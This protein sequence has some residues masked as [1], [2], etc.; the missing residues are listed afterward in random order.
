MYL[1][2]V[3]SNSENIDFCLTT[4]VLGSQIKLEFL[5][6]DEIQ[7][8]RR[9]ILGARMRT[10]N[11]LH[12][13]L[14]F[15]TTVGVKCSHHCVVLAPQAFVL[16]HVELL[17]SCVACQSRVNE[18]RYFPTQNVHDFASFSKP[19]HLTVAIFRHTEKRFQAS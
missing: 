19:T 12:S 10:N 11:K 1:I 14:P 18:G 15:G 4:V 16:P 5:R 2:D 9:K 3:F 17:F 7:S 6:R 13:H 8:T